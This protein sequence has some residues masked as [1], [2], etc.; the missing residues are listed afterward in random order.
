[1]P[2]EHKMVW[3]VASKNK[4]VNQLTENLYGS[5]IYV[6]K[7]R[8]VVAIESFIAPT[9][10]GKRRQIFRA[11]LLQ[12]K[13]YQKHSTGKYEKLPNFIKVRIGFVNKPSESSQRQT[14]ELLSEI[15]R[16]RFYK[17]QNSEIL[18]IALKSLSYIRKRY[19]CNANS[20]PKRM[21]MNFLPDPWASSFDIL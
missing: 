17:P 20:V 1:M 10:T 2:G 5:Q 13:V 9:T 15:A 3:T 19:L 16:E 12:R 6:L 18:G 21:Q 11:W 8:G 7:R 4:L 14:T